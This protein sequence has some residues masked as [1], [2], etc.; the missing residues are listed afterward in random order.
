MDTGRWKGR[1]TVR[2]QKYDDS[3]YHI[4]KKPGKKNQYLKN[5]YVSGSKIPFGRKMK[6]SNRIFTPYLYS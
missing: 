1:F 3:A 4:L 5:E 6:Y 2:L